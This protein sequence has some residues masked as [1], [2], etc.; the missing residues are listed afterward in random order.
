MR[1]KKI[2]AALLACASLIRQPGNG[3]AEK[4]FPKT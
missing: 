2:G 1:F 4:A 3:T